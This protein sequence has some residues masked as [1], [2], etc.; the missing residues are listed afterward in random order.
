MTSSEMTT[1]DEASSQDDESTTGSDSNTDSETSEGD[2]NESSSESEDSTSE[3][4][5]DEMERSEAGGEVEQEKI[6]SIGVLSVPSDR[7]LNEGESDEKKEMV[8]VEMV[9]TEA[10]AP[11]DSKEDV[12]VPIHAPQN[13]VR[14]TVKSSEPDRKAKPQSNPAVEALNTPEG[15][16]ST[17]TK[18]NSSSD[19][20]FASGGWGDEPDPAPWE[21]KAMPLDY[22]GFL[23]EQR[24]T[25]FHEF[26]VSDGKGE[27]L[28]P[29]YSGPPN[30]FGIAV[31]RSC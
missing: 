2:T 30:Y 28:R 23:A 15:M 11:M 19:N 17:S 25:V 24:R 7:I 18:S 10:I 5:D 14:N 16:D 21:W 20:P 4:E 1:S 3:E 26:R 29:N 6:A 27:W 12:P 13:V 8:K 22:M 31:L 9:S